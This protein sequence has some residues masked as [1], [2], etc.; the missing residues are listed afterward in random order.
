MLGLR[1]LLRVV[2]LWWT[3][4]EDENGTDDCEK[5]ER[6]EER[7]EESRCSRNSEMDVSHERHR[8]W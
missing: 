2:R 7:K 3:G 4:G 8:T 1:L 6:E 5:E